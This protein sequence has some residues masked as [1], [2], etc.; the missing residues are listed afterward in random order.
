MTRVWVK[1]SRAA[2]SLSAVPSIEDSSCYSLSSGLQRSR[3]YDY[4]T[5]V[6]SERV[7][8]RP[9]FD[10]DAFAVR[11]LSGSAPLLTPVD[12]STARARTVTAKADMSD[13]LEHRAQVCPFLL[14]L[15]I[16]HGQHHTS[17]HST[18]LTASAHPQLL[19]QLH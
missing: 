7:R 2:R 16:Q 11:R 8:T 5:F 18:A 19:L 9:I 4:P 17:H 1:G 12:P 10:L 15:F 3:Y 14:R 13:S 6:R